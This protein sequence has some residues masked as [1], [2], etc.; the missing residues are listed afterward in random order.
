VKQAATEPLHITHLVPNLNYGGL[1]EVV[2]SLCLGQVGHGHDVSVLCWDPTNN[3][4]EAAEQL[5]EAGVRAT[6][7]RGDAR[8]PV[9]S[10]RAVWDRLGS[11]R[12]DVLHI[13]NPF[14]YCIYGAL[15]GGPR[16][17]TK[18]V[19]T[20]HATAMFD[21]FGR[22]RKVKFW[23]STLMT[24]RV[25]AV[26]DEIREIAAARF[27]LPAR[28]LAVVENGID[29]SPYL[30]IPARPRRDDVVF[31]AVGRMSPT[32]NQR[33]LVEA[34]A[35]VRQQHPGIRLRLLGSGTSEEPRLRALVETLELGDAVEF[36]G[37]S[38]D[39]AGF[40][41]EIDVFVLPS[42]SEGLPLS[43]LEAIASGLPVV[44]TDVGG[45][46]KVVETTRSGR[47]CAPQ[48][49]DTLAAAMAATIEDGDRQSNTDRSRQIVA[50][51][52]SVER[53]TND[54]DRLYREL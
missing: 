42:K 25:V 4:P 8:R 12:V 40:L 45:V 47:V 30:S 11:E 22:K 46:R 16:R 33:Q 36:C 39:V 31:G 20:L 53:M 35:D 13:H 26:C 54:Y 32:K 23:A 21:R 37:Y 29:A 19:N 5:E 50:E 17:G 43:L 49:V 1:Q 7:A 3:H 28:K 27:H 52:Y 10:M 51:Q 15:A 24:N 6:S 14:D 34:F 9:A 2:R 38:H 41:G 18:V 48:R 44:A